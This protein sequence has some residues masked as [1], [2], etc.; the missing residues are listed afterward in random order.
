MHLPNLKRAAATLA[1]V[2]GIA[3]AA[4]AARAQIAGAAATGASTTS[5][6]PADTHPTTPR[7]LLKDGA[8]T[9]SPTAPANSAAASNSTA[10][11]KT[12]TQKVAD[13]LKAAAA[14]I[15]R[16]TYAQRRKWEMAQASL[17]SFC[18]K[19]DALLHDRETNNLAHLDWHEKQGYETA[20]YTGYGDVQ[21][22]VCK[23]SD[24]GVPIGKLTYEERNY[25]L[26]GKTT[27]E[28]KSHPKLISVT[29]TLEIFSYEKD[30]WFY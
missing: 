14:R 16:L 26:A 25:Y 24:E 19:W 28:A 7:L 11:T 27:A 20:S 10:A 6:L 4:H 21:S 2:I 13:D 8:A 15:A 18:H 29:K 17:P 5:N 1:L 22:C 30:R 12:S 9:L 23:E 3:L